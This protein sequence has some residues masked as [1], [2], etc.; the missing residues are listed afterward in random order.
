MKRFLSAIFFFL[1][2]TTIG[3][4]QD[5]SSENEKAP[6]SF[7]AQKYQEIVQ[8]I[9]YPGRRTK[10]AK[11]A[12]IYHEAHWLEKQGRFEE[13]I[14]KYQEALDPELI[15][16]ERDKVHPLMGIVRIHQA[17]GEYELALQ[18]MD[19]FL[20]LAPGKDDYQRKKKEIE[21]L[22]SAKDENSPQS[23]YEFIQYYRKKY[24]ESVPPNEIT[25]YGEILFSSFVYLY[26]IIGDFDAGIAL[27]DEFRAKATQTPKVQNEYLKI[28]KA[29]E[30][31]EKAGRES[32]IN[33]PGQIGRATRALMR[34]DYFSW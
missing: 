27:C 9:N 17:Q 13:A 10:Q 21:V 2:I 28:R 3:F 4:S 25:T 30:E 7:N 5:F 16:I 32:F 20:K 22:I 34:S 24:K 29:F 8:A 11:R 19:W 33:K 31:D 15:D 12:K 18:E 14:K 26:D 6:K 1:L 23:L